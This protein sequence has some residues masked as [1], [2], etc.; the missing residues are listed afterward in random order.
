MCSCH[1]HA[2][3]QAVMLCLRFGP[4]LGHSSC[5]LQQSVCLVRQGEEGRTLSLKLLYS[6]HCQSSLRD[7]PTTLRSRKG[8]RQG[9]GTVGKGSTGRSLCVRSR[10]SWARLARRSY[11]C[12]S[13][14][15][16]SR[17][18]APWIVARSFRRAFDF[19]PGRQGQVLLQERSKGRGIG[20]AA[21]ETP[22]PEGQGPRSSLTGEP[23]APQR[24]G[25]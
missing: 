17:C 12:G 4:C 22:A 6:C 11:C 3:H 1:G 9:R 10:Q 23:L 13:K 18:S 20:D 15:Q 25:G 24:H 5:V 8:M 2:A 16:G 21:K 19:A 14:T 7:W